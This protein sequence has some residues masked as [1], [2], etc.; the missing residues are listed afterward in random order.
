MM[1]FDDARLMAW[2]DGELDAAEGAE[3]EAA[4]AADPALAARV[5]EQRRLRDRLRAHYGPVA[6]E[7][8]PE[9]LSAL[10]ETNVVAFS[11]RRPSSRPAW[12]LPAAIAASLVLGLFGGRLLPGGDGP[13]ALDAGRLEARGALASALDAQLASDQRAEAETRIGISF[14]RADGRWCRTFEGVALSGLACRD[15]GGWQLVMT[16]EGRGAQGGYRQ[17]GSGR[18][19]GAAQEMMAGEPL[20]AA[21]ERAARDSGWQARR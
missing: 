14:A 15:A 21:G 1:T 20:D 17:A 3:V 9:R 6:D 12:Q 4:I 2:L 16:D 10:L 5:E 19:L 11:P 7:P 13:V 18:I 8:V